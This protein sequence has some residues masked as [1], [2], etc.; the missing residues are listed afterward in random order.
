MNRT[1]V[2]KVLPTSM[3]DNGGRKIVQM[4]AFVIY[5]APEPGLLAKRAKVAALGVAV[6]DQEAIDAA[7]K[8][9]GSSPEG[10]TAVLISD[11][12][13]EDLANLWFRFQLQAMLG[14]AV[15]P[16]SRI[17]RPTGRH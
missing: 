9:L 1:N 6:S 13:T 4:V 12:P 3:A 16:E 2:Q 17:V 11:A 7:A 10:M 15:T 5:H 8:E 14:A